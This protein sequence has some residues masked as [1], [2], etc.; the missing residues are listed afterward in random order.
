[1]HLQ[2]LIRLTIRTKEEKRKYKY[3][4]HFSQFSSY[5]SAQVGL[6]CRHNHGEPKA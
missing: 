6:M 5:A 1:M 3:Q 4:Y 2:N